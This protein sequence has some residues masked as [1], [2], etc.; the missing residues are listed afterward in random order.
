MK[1]LGKVI[2]ILLCSLGGFLFYTDN[3]KGATL[4]LDFSNY[5]FER[6]DKNGNNYASW[7]LDYYYIDGNVAYCIEPGLDE[8]KTME[9]GTWEDT[10]L[11]ENIQ[12]KV[13]LTAYYGYT[14]PSH[15]T[16]KYRAA[17]QAL[18]WETIL[19]NGTEVTY[20]TKRYGKGESYNVSIEKEAIN[21]LVKRHYDKPS[22]SETTITSQVGKSTTLTDTNNVLSNFEVSSSVGADAQIDKNNLKVTPTI[23]GS[24]T[25]TFSK[26]L[27]YQTKYRIF[28][29]DGIQ[30]MLVPGMIDSV[31]FSLKIDAYYGEINITKKDQE[32]GTA[33]GQATLKGA[34][35][36]IYR[37][38]DGKQITSI[39][40]DENG[41]ASTGKILSADSYFVKEISSSKGYELDTTSYDVEL[42]DKE[43]IH[44]DVKEKVLKGRIKINKVDSETNRCE[45]S[46]QGSLAGSQYGIY[47]KNNTL[48]ETITI[49]E[50][51]QAISKELPYDQYKVK[52]LKAGKGYELDTTV[53]SVMITSAN[54]V[55]ITSKEHIIKNYVSILKQYN[56]VDENTTF[57]NAESDILFEIYYPDG[58]KYGE[59]TTDKNGYATVNLPYGVWKFHQV[60]VVPGYEK[61]YDFYITVDENSKEQQYYN[62][63][64]NALSAYL[65]VYKIDWETNEPIA[66]ANTTFKIL[67]VDTNQYVSQYVGGKIYDTFTTDETGRM[68]TY[69]KLE[70]G[71][72][73]LIEVESPTG[74]VLSDEKLSFTIGENSYYSYTTY[75]AFITVYFKNK[76]IKGQIEIHKMG[77]L[78]QMKN[79]TYYYDKQ[80]LGEI[81]FNIY[82]DEVIQSP[83]GKYTYYYKN[84]LVD[85]VKTD[86]DGYA[87]SKELPLG[88]YYILEASTKKGYILDSKKYSFE[89]KA[90]DNRTPIV[91]ENISICNYL[92]KGILEFTKLDATTK[93][94][95]GGTLIE[96]YSE[97]NETLFTGTT[98]ENGKIV[99]SDLVVGN[100]YL[101]EKE[102]AEG[103][104]IS[105]EKVS[106]KIR[107]DSEVVKVEMENEKIKSLITIIKKDGNGQV[108]KGV[109]IGIYDLD[110]N[111]I[112]S[113]F[114]ND[115]GKIE[116]TLEYGKY[117]YQE[118]ET[119]DS[120][121]LDNEKYY[122]DVL[123]SE[124]HLEFELINRKEEINVPETFKNK[125]VFL[126][127]ISFL[128]IILGTSLFAYEKK[129]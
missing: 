121:I 64:N 40:T 124:E 53:Y 74:Y 78:F 85:T 61:I 77:E 3:V 54:T 37:K 17:T 6:S 81:V 35:Y 95:V 44:L 114:T 112:Y 50:N 120:Y 115:E 18:I 1:Q 71:N 22:F 51:C 48:L 110:G 52:E 70:A 128:C 68:V 8:G 34:V 60:N 55:E 125:N 14:Y 32:T 33:Q 42:I 111:L 94:G 25:L 79:N 20:S 39:T 113:A 106:F 62:I 105:N 19:G 5:Y 16:D 21:A 75:G 98:D 36:G 123:H 43:S 91:Y 46:G 66:I 122:F 11:P 117:Y 49:D 27:A 96:V 56:F 83:D 84:D 65:Q 127:M 45:E 12:E 63:L 31:T 99:I 80:P 92:E 101:I 67:N 129:K 93:E 104:I 58:T 86:K 103:Y 29:G 88:K 82:A 72:Y 9:E 28:Y 107:K 7:K 4:S 2:S 76:P 69:L 38:S 109:K 26:K 87:I 89:L 23:D 100:Y 47:D 59:V 24:I 102:P 30:N 90:N 57:L 10:G 108:L 118:L 15:Q 116:V 97:D 73:Q 119:I 41:K 126:E 13:L